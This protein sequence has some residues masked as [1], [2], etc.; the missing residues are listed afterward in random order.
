MDRQ[1]AAVRKRDARGS[2]SSRCHGPARFYKASQSLLYS[3]RFSDRKLNGK[4]RQRVRKNPNPVGDVLFGGILIRTMAD[5]LATRNEQHGNRTDS[6][7]EERIVVRPAD[8]A[9]VTEILLL[10]GRG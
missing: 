7:H 2:N 9:P 8:D 6:R 10:T 3:V 5:T 4:S 1:N